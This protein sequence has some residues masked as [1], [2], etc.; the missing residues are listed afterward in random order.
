MRCHK[1]NMRIQFLTGGWLAYLG[2]FL[3]S[4]QPY[5]GG[6]KSICCFVFSDTIHFCQFMM[7]SEGMRVFGLEREV[8]RFVLVLFEQS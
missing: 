2:V 7:I 5:R 4:G 8:L 1:T 6:K 3:R